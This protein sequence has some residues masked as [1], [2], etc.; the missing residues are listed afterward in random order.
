MKIPTT[1]FVNEHCFLNWHCSLSQN[2]IFECEQAWRFKACYGPGT[3]NWRR[4]LVSLAP[5]QEATFRPQRWHK[6]QERS[7]SFF[8]I[9]QPNYPSETSER[10]SRENLSS[11]RHTRCPDCFSSGGIDRSCHTRRIETARMF[12]SESRINTPEDFVDLLGLCR[13][14]SCSSVKSSKFS[15]GSLDL[16]NSR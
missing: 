6:H 13:L 15:N 9:W 8:A 12:L 2:L 3:Y 1:L 16:V 4:E 5:P 10:S 14:T 11:Y 7:G